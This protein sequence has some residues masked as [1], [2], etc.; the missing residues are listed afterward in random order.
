MY[1]LASATVWQQAHLGRADGLD[2]RPDLVLDEQV[3]H[4]AQGLDAAVEL[5]VVVRL[6]PAHR[7][8]DDQQVRRRPRPAVKGTSRLR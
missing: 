1:R 6:R 3:G 7:A 4:Q 5:H 8:G 2:G